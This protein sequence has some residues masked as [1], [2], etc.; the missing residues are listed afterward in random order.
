MLTE[1]MFGLRVSRLACVN[2]RRYTYRGC[3]NTN[4]T[5]RKRRTR[6]FKLTCVHQI[7]SRM[8]A[9]SRA[10]AAAYVWWRRQ[11]SLIGH[12]KIRWLLATY[13]VCLLV[14]TGTVFDSL[15]ICARRDRRI[16]L[17][18]E[19]YVCVGELQVPWAKRIPAHCGNPRRGY[20]QIPLSHG[21]NDRYRARWIV[22]EVF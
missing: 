7:T 1:R 21:L 9:V 5:D 19:L 11:L 20:F 2:C 4:I 18:Y 12:V 22:C 17:G 16:W 13:S 8:A 3:A 6:H 14:G 15:D 10:S